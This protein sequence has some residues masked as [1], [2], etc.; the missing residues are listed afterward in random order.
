[1]TPDLGLLERDRGDTELAGGRE[2]VPEA[3]EGLGDLAVEARSELTEPPPAV[4]GAA[5]IKDRAQ[6][7]GDPS[8]TLSPLLSRV[9]NPRTQPAGT[10]PFF[11]QR[12]FR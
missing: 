12:A 3:A 5:G 7:P 4:G 10:R 11:Q 1:M 6:V 8:P 2:T 9:E